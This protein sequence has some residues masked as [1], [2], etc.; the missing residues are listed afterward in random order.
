MPPGQ[1]AEVAAQAQRR[2]E[3]LYLVDRAVVLRLRVPNDAVRPGL[4]RDAEGPREPDPQGGLVVR[5]TLDLGDQRHAQ[6]AVS[7]ASRPRI[8]A[9]RRRHRHGAARHRQGA[10]H[11]AEPRA[12]AR[13]RRTPS[14]TSYNYSVDT[15]YGG[16][17]GMQAGSTFKAFTLAAALAKGIPIGETLTAPAQGYY[18][19]GDFTD[20]SGRTGRHLPALDAGQLHDLGH[21]LAQHALRDR[22]VGQHLLHRAREAGR[23]V[24]RRDDGRE[25]GGA[26]GVRS[27]PAPVASFTLGTSLVTPLTMANA[28]ATFAARGRYCKPVVVISVTQRRQVP[29][30]A[31]GGLPPGDR[32]VGRRRRQ[33]PARRRDRR[34]DSG[35]YRGRDVAGPTSRRQD[36]NHREQRRGLVHRLHTQPRGR[37]VGRQPQG[38]HRSLRPGQ[39]HD[40]RHVLLPRVRRSARGA[41]LEGGDA[42]RRGQP[43]GRVLQPRRSEPALRRTGRRA[44]RPRQVTQRG[45]GDA[46]RGR[47]PGDAVAD[48]RRLRRSPPARSARPRR[49]RAAPRRLEP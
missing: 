27:R 11:G 39:R 8:P 32:A 43:A 20:C 46:G 23:P 4:R 48:H 7:R 15:A 19:T 34:P 25:A 31:V 12:T 30:G 3:R 6:H 16:T 37:R 44:Q 28:Y 10:G 22:V 24:Q 1:A 2:T 9:C 18:I 49:H 41:D 35:P 5:T 17:H 45:H 13:I 38:R 29:T 14:V 26:H 21:E 36:G 33:Q 42:G 40:Q 47:L